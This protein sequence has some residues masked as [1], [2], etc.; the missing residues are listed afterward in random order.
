MK[1]LLLLTTVVIALC[2]FR[3]TATDPAPLWLR[4]PSISPDGSTIVFTYKGDIYKVNATG[5]TATPLTLSEG[6]DFMPVW[7]PDGKSI[8]FASDRNGNYDVYVM[9]ATGGTA[10]R[11]TF[12]S[13]G[14]YPSCFSPDGASVYF[15]STRID[16]VSNVMFP[17]G[18]L[19]ELYMVP[20]KGGKETQVVSV[21]AEDAKW[22][23][24]GNRLVFHDRKGYEDP[25]RKHHV[26]SVAR[27][28]WMYTKKENKYTKLTDFAGEDRNPVFSTDEA[29]L[30][31]LS[32]KSGTYNVWKMN[33]TDPSKNTQITKFEKDPVRF[34]SMSA[35]G[36]LCF[37]QNGELY[38][39]TASGDAQK[40]TVKIETD[41]RYTD[42]KTETFT[43]GATDMDVS[44]NGKEVVFV[45][46]GEVFVSSVDGG[47]TKRITNTPG[48]ER[49]V[50]FSPDG[51]SILYAS[52]RNNIWGI[53]QSSLTRKEESLFFNSTVL[54]EESIL[55]G[56]T[57]AFQPAWS[58]DGKEI[59]YLED[60]TAVKIINLKTKAVRQI[61]AAEKNYSYSDGD[62][63]FDWS[64]DGKYLLVQFLQ[65][66][67]WLTE[68]GLIE[69][70]GNGKLV[71]LTQSG[72]D[73][74][75]PK[76]A[77][78]GRMMLWMSNRHGMKNLGSHGN[79]LDVYGMFFTQAAYD[80]FKLSKEDFALLK[81]KEDKDKNKDKDKAKADS[82][83]KAQE[84]VKI[85]LE[86][87]ADRKAR[88]TI[89]SSD[90]ADA[91][92][93]K[94][95]EQL[96]YLSR[97][98]K[99]Y[100]LWANKFRENETKMLMRLDASSAG[101]LKMDKEGKNLFLLADGKILKLNIEKPEK[102]EIAFNAE[103]NLNTVEE[104]A[105]EFEHMWRQVVKKFYVT[106]LQK[107]DW[108]Y[109][110]ENYVRFLPHINN[111]RDY[112][113]MMSEL[114][115]E[116][117]ASHT[118]C[119]YSPRFKNPDETASLGIF[120]DDTYT[121]KGM[122]VAEVIDK[123]PLI[124]AVS[125][126]KTGTIIEKIDGQEIA[127]ETNIYKLL[128]RKAGKY[129]LLSLYDETSK[130]RWEETVKPIGPGALN[131]LL[132]QR[133]VKK[134]QDL[135][136]KASNGQ[137]GYMHVRGMND[138]SYRA[139]Y[140]QVMGKYS[141]KKAL[142]V[143][144]RFNGGGW[145]HD[146]LA[147][148]LSGKKYIEFMPRERKIGVEPQAKWT[149]ASAVLMSEGNYSDAHMFPVV[150]KTLNIGK[151]IGMPVPGTGTAVWWENLQDQTLVFGIP[152]VGVMTMDGKYYEN[153]QLEPDFKVMNEYGQVTGGKDQ[154]LEKAIEVLLQQAGG[155]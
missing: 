155:K 38:T 84:P 28:V 29:D 60:R 35:S 73:N 94:D 42:A 145:L 106:D 102:K 59:A 36:L 148:F 79:Q 112:A 116:L 136:E 17:S 146:D 58:P 27:D 120:Y 69:T 87:I 16:N 81:E 14:D 89:H 45:V 40:V 122:K 63:W 121:G 39:K 8:A 64:P 141:N 34:L 22:D 19:P 80:R 71:D 92:L 55:S 131:E 93:S 127:E 143:D 103:M 100:D 132:Y 26:S 76:W 52:E 138:E 18:V 85:E 12:Y 110:K 62:Q 119:R 24:A 88:L 152:Q 137:V 125:Q 25:W 128:N 144:T 10:K 6:H 104:R 91:I 96:F 7:S 154:Q 70:S 113:E 65:D 153:N 13:S 150:Y 123:S 135:T 134:M 31:Y 109:Y 95:G 56:K 129:T 101:N 82:V 130:K 114:L 30:F 83:Q 86:N 149:R 15:T 46:R 54:L 117:N 72:F 11:L 111:N 97:F 23:K 50:S 140:E 151:T 124:Q 66:G 51:R 32:E 47:I 1:K 5:G 37:S 61:L 105:Y 49:S 75:A 99:G 78:N 115:G 3:F 2:A 77:M 98:E 57:E 33:I 126:I 147:T 44:P 41:E 9:P 142:I 133:W 53:Y 67:N 21:P 43:T 74:A 118:G 90:L 48:Q 139:F 4:Y 68:A 107:T 20:A 108:N